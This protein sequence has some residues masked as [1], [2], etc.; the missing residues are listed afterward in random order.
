MGGLWEPDFERLLD[1]IYRRGEPDRVPFFELGIDLEIEQ[2][3]MGA[4]RPGGE[5]GLRYRIEFARRMGYDYVRAGVGFYF[6]QRELL[7]AT[8]TAV[9]NRGRRSWR[10]EH[11]GLIASWADFDA[12]P[13]PEVTPSILADLEDL[14]PL[15]PA[16]MK[17]NTSYAGVWEYTV[18]LIGFEPLCYLLA[19]DAELVRAVADRVGQ[20]QVEMYDALCDHPALGS[21]MIADDLGF[22][23]HTMVSPEVLRTMFF[24]WLERIVACIHAHGKAALL[25]ACGSWSAIMEDLLDIGFDAFHSF[26]DVIEPV[27]AFKRAWGDRAAALGGIDVHVLAAGSEQQVREYAGRVIEECK[28]GG[29]WALGSGNTVANYIPVANYLAMLDEGRRHGVY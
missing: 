12:Y 16:G 10:D 25:H 22:K 27:A 15:L 5:D 3:V 1:A 17:C 4:P 2:A 11:H 23:T 9:Q 29:G 14:A 19:D 21:C 28:P 24:P 20:C 7:Y 8:D 26:E 18:L 13:W 6:P